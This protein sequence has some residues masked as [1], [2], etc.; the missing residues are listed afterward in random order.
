MNAVV[1]TAVLS[2]LN[3]GLYTAPRMLFVLAGRREAP[4]LM[5]RV[6]SRGVPTPPPTSPSPLDPATRNHNDA[7]RWGAVRCR[8]CAGRSAYRSGR[9]RSPVRVVISGLRRVLSF[10]T[11]YGHV[12]GRVQAAEVMPR[13]LVVV[14]CPRAAPL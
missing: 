8:R 6:R 4:A 1:L 3:F 14:S 10:A 12:A 11:A 7:G 5:T 9:T 13:Y 2:C